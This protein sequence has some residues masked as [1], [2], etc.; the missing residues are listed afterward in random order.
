MGEQKKNQDTTP[1][2]TRARS[3]KTGNKT[4]QKN[5]PKATRMKEK[6]VFC[7]VNRSSYNFQLIRLH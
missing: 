7:K 2:K 5:G 3:Q 1:M 4:K 6:I